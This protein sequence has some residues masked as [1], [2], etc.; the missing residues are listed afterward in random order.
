MKNNTNTTTTTTAMT[1]LLFKH[2]QF[3]TDVV[4]LSSLPRVNQAAYAN[5]LHGEGYTEISGTLDGLLK[6][7]PFLKSYLDARGR[8]IL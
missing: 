4:N 7:Y 5:F 1:T 2:E 3:K 8:V 6:D